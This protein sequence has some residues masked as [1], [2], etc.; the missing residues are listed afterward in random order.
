MAIQSNIIAIGAKY[1]SFP[2]GS[3]TSFVYLIE[4][5]DNSHVSSL[6]YEYESF[7]MYCTHTLIQFY[8][9]SDFIHIW[10]AIPTITRGDLSPK[11]FN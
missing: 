10:E 3:K 4:R 2:Q 6:G 5:R 8:N 11:I 9:F 1:I 7:I